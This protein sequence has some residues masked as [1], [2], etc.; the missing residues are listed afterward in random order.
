MDDLKKLMCQQ[1][2]EALFTVIPRIHEILTALFHSMHDNHDI[3]DCDSACDLLRALV[4]FI[5]Q[6]IFEITAKHLTEPTE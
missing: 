5:E 2:F 6:M 1:A 3:F 4:Q